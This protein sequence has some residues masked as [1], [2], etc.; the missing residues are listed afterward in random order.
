MDRGGPIATIK[1]MPNQ[2]KCNQDTKYK[3]MNLIF[4]FNFGGGGVTVGYSFG[5]GPFGRFLDVGEGW[6]KNAEKIVDVHY[7][8]PLKLMA[9]M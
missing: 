2:T 5:E 6:V 1:Y 8:R 4:T 7:A 9:Y 3:K